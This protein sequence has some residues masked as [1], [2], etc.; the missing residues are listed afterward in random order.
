MTLPVSARLFLYG[1]FSTRPLLSSSF[2]CHVIT[3]QFLPFRL[4]LLL[5]FKCQRGV[6]GFFYL[7]LDFTSS[8][9]WSL[10]PHNEFCISF[11][12]RS[13]CT[14]N[15]AFTVHG[16]A[17][18][19]FSALDGVT[20]SCFWVSRAVSGNWRPKMWANVNPAAGTST[21]NC[22]IHRG[23]ADYALTDWS[24]VFQAWWS[25]RRSSTK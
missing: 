16:A 3:L 7:F 4:L 25:L 18:L 24:D 13:C 8:L 11:V 2:S 17:A 23:S 5:C 10:C 20:P 14:N 12:F 1:V 21:C 15:P 19:V 22:V 6:P 9:L